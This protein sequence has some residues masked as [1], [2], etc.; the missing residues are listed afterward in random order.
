M[1]SLK[2]SVN[3]VQKINLLQSYI[4]PFLLNFIFEY[5]YFYQIQQTSGKK[6]RKKSQYI[7]I[8]ADLDKIINYCPID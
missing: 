1:L 2:A 5:I 3:G 7:S 6:E 8:M 4:F